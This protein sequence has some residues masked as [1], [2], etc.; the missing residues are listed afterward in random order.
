MQ[1][2]TGHV[3]DFAQQCENGSL[4]KLALRKGTPL[5]HVHCKVKIYSIDSFLT[6]DREVLG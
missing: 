5:L 3:L 1:N 4:S 2:V 6:L